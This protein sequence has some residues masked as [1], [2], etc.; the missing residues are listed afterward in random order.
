[1]ADNKPYLTKKRPFLPLVLEPWHLS[2]ELTPTRTVGE[3]GFHRNGSAMDIWIR[4]NGRFEWFAVDNLELQQGL[5]E[6]GGFFV[7]RATSDRNA[8]EGS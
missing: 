8:E 3:I 7:L 2:G 6:A 4:V 5:R 1:M